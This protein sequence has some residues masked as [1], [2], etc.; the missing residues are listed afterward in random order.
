M[1]SRM[2]ID[3]V[4]DALTMSIWR[5]RLETDSPHHSDQVRQF[6]REQ[7][8][9]LVGTN[10]IECSMSLARECHDHAVMESFFS[11]MK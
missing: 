4:P 3:V 2:T 8:Q 5:R 9:K 7:F 11:R 1:K 6:T 10:G